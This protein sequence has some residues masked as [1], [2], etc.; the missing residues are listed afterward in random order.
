MAFHVFSK[1]IILETWIT[2]MSN[3]KHTCR[4]LEDFSSSDIMTHR[5]DLSSIG[6]MTRREDLSSIDIMTQQEGTDICM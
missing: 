4:L 5:E 2:K 6:M 1:S 3:N